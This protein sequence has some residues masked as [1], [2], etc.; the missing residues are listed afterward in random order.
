MS[1]KS[2]LSVILASFVPD[3][4]VRHHNRRKHWES[5]QLWSPSAL[6]NLL[7]IT[8]DFPADRRQS[9]RQQ[10]ICLLRRGMSSEQA[11]RITLVDNR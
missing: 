4:L 6:T 11:C 2:R 3:R 7:E 1:L 8:K 10:Y 5:P 9:A